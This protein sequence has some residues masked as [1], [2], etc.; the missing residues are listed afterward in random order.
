MPELVLKSLDQGR[1]ENLQATHFAL[2]SD[3]HQ[4]ESTNKA[5]FYPKKSNW[6]DVKNDAK[7]LSKDLKSSHFSLGQHKDHWTTITKDS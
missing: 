5:D 3:P 4:F 2:G 7:A 1:K 6:Q